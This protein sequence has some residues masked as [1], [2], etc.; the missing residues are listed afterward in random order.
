[1]SRNYELMQRAALNLESASK[2]EFAQLLPRDSQVKVGEKVI[3]PTRPNHS[4]AHVASQEASCLVQSVFQSKGEERRTVVFAAIN[5]GSGCSWMI[6][7]VAQVLARSVSGSVCLVEANLRTPT[8]PEAFG[9]ANHLGLADAL[10]QA[11]P[12]RQFITPLNS[13]N[14]SLLSSGS[15]PEASINLLTSDRMREIVHELRAEFDYVLIDA[16]PL[17]AYA[18]TFSVGQLGD[19]LVLV[20]EANA[21]RRE[22]AARVTERL[23]E[24]KVNILGAVLNKR[25]FPI[26]SFVYEWL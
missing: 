19:G 16:P 18:D 12:I 20:L 14:L 24:M 26:P 10:R 23:R 9:V 13:A 7:R 15:S 6:A 8:L 4:L 21:T 5:S 22:S 3:V 17:G 2:G 11:Q 25:T 1:M